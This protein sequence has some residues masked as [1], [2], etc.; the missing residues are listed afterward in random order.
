MKHDIKKVQKT[1]EKYFA[2]IYDLID[3]MEQLKASIDKIEDKKDRAM[4]NKSYA[5]ARKTLSSM[6]KEADH[7]FNILFSK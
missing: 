2:T 4:V 6:T 7:F 3:T 5:R 1:A